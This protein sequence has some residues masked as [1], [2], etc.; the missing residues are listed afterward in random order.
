MRQL[1]NIVYYEFLMQVKSWRF[2]GMV[3]LSIILCI[4]LYQDG[5]RNNELLPSRTIFSFDLLPF[6]VI[7]TVFAGFFAIGRVRKTGMAPILFVRPWATFLLPLGQVIGALLSLMIPLC[8]ISFPVGMILHYQIEIAYPLRPIVYVLLFYF[9]PGLSVLLALSIWVRAC[10][11]NN[12]MALIVT[13]ILLAGVAALSDITLGIFVPLVSFFS[14]AYWQRIEKIQALPLIPFDRFVDWAQFGASMLLTSVFILLTCYHLRRTEPH[15]KVMGSYGRHWYHTPTFVRMACDLKTDPHVTWKSHVL[16]ALMIGFLGY[17]NVWPVYGPPLTQWVEHKFAKASGLSEAEARL[18]QKEQKY[19]ARNIPDD[20]ILPI[21]IVRNDERI[22]PNK[23]TADLTFTCPPLETI[24]AQM[25]LTT[26]TV[27]A[28]DGTTIAQS[29]TSTT[30]ALLNLMWRVGYRIESMTVDTEPLHFFAPPHGQTAYIEESAIGPYLDGTTHTLRIQARRD[31][32]Y[33]NDESLAGETMLHVLGYTFIQRRQISKSQNGELSIAYDW[34]YL[35]RF[36]TRLTFVRDKPGTLLLTP[37]LPESI[38]AITDDPDGPTA[39][40]FEV[41][42]LR[43]GLSNYLRFLPLYQS[44]IEVEAGANSY[45]FVSERQ[46]EQTLLHLAEL[47]RPTLVEFSE[48]YAICSSLPLVIRFLNRGELFSLRRFISQYQ[49]ERTVE[50]WRQEEIFTSL[51]WLEKSMLQ[52][53]LQQTFPQYMRVPQN[54]AYDLHTVFEMNYARGLNHRLA[55]SPYE[56]PVFGPMPCRK[57]G[58]EGA[59]FQE[60]SRQ[61]LQKRTNHPPVFQM[62][63]LVLGHDR[64]TQMIRYLGTENKTDELTPELIQ[65]Q[66]VRVLKEPAP[67]DIDDRDTVVDLPEGYENL[68]WFFD[69]WL[70]TGTGYPSWS[71]ESAT[72]RLVSVPDADGDGKQSVYRVRARIVN[73]GTGTM[74]VPV[75]METSQKRQQET[76]WIGPGETVTWETESR[77]VPN[78]VAVDPLGWIL[79]LA[80]RDPDTNEWDTHQRKVTI[81][82]EED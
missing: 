21:R 24:R 66:A 4:T 33:L 14:F 57:S 62:L 30:I 20:A 8:I 37:V 17:H 1:F 44:I 43:N 22:D 48:R 61:E 65:R 39:Y 72:A 36:P 58:R 18:L 71:V 53:I 47:A 82:E 59:Q 34:R 16:L 79:S 5:I 76:L 11:K 12:L 73:H 69:Y 78:R 7:A 23:L 15:R 13:G 32:M 45:R 67:T 46:F 70:R 81:I 77:S 42:A 68:D 80:H 40:V 50:T 56:A 74:P 60:L 25:S 75:W 38:E 51:G 26:T 3:A 31:A 6:T 9:V 28:D 10:F 64:W 54:S 52:Q 19:L 2:R 35:D 49:R 63:Y 41:P 27:T 29:P 55:L